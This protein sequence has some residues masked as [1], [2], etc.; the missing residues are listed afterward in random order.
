MLPENRAE[1]ARVYK[2]DGKRLNDRGWLYYPV[3]TALV[4]GLGGLLLA[5]EFETTPSK[6][7]FWGISL[8]GVCGFFG[9]A[10]TRLTATEVREITVPIPENIEKNRQ[11]IDEWSR[12]VSIIQQQNAELLGKKNEEI[13]KWRLMCEKEQT[14]EL[15]EAI[16]Q[17]N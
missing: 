15:I 2:G 6:G 10:M 11:M 1:K 16:H 5:P 4:C 12:Q 13:S 9:I 3:G 8:G 14:N 17:T 7:F